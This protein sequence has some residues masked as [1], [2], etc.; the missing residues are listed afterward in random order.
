VVLDDEEV[1]AGLLADILRLH[2]HQVD[3]FTNPHRA[4]E[5]IAAGP[6]DVFFTDL[7]MP[8]M[9]GWDVAREALRLR[10]ALPIVLVTGWGDQIEMTEIQARGIASLVPKPYEQDHI[11]RLVT[12]ILSRPSPS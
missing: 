3:V 2:H 8:E 5:R 6:T 7:G 12:E 1:L 11:L 10:P 9:S 4:L